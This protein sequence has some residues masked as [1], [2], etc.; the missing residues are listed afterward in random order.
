MQVRVLIDISRRESNSFDG[1]LPYA[2]TSDPIIFIVSRAQNSMPAVP[3]SPEEEGHGAQELCDGSS[4]KPHNVP[5]P[6][7]REPS[8]RVIDYADDTFAPQID[9]ARSA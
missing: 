6:E 3:V 2:P 4:T 8:H 9:W 7:L 1:L 5:Q